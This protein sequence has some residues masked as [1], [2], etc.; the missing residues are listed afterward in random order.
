M[1]SDNR[2]LWSAP[3]RIPS[4]LTTSQSTTEPLLPRP[5]ISHTSNHILGHYRNNVTPNSP[6]TL[7]QLSP[8]MPTHN[9]SMNETYTYNLPNNMT[10]NVPTELT[11][12][13]N[14]FI[15]HPNLNTHYW[16]LTTKW[17]NFDYYIYRNPT[18]EYYWMTFEWNLPHIFDWL[19]FYTL[20][21]L[22]ALYH[23]SNLFLKHTSNSIYYKF[24]Y[25]KNTRN[26]TFMS[27]REGTPGPDLIE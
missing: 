20:I 8:I 4:T 10:M 24:I 15:L 16:H 27:R 5:T 22:N 6:L 25:K 2:S 9:M 14:T 11:P 17:L 18:V 12:F 1:T 7:P 19:I 3:A 23:T 21:Y 26:R 13:Q